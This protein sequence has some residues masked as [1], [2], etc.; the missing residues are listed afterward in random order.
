MWF[1]LAPWVAFGAGLIIFYWSLR[2]SPRSPGPPSRYY[3]SPPDIVGKPAP[4]ADTDWNDDQ[5]FSD[6]ERHKTTTS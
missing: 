6:R 1:V 3:E 5:H 4:P 2:R